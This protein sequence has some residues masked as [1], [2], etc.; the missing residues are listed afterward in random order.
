MSI[1]AR[2]RA[3]SWASTSPGSPAWPTALLSSAR[4]RTT[5]STRL[6]HLHR[7]DR[8]LPSLVLGKPAP[9]PARL[10]NSPGELF[11][12]YQLAARA[13][14]SARFVAMA[15]YGDYGPGYIGTE[16]AY[17]Q[18]SYKTHPGSSFVAPNVDRVLTDAIRRLFRD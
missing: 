16:V 5:T 12:E 11:A 10:L 6:G 1:R 7:V 15:A 8:P 2:P 3:S 9:E 14:R 4:S 13:L 17:S 18:G